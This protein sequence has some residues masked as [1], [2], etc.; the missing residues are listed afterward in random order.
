MALVQPLESYNLY[1]LGNFISD[2]KIAIDTG[3]RTYMAYLLSVAIAGGA[4]GEATTAKLTPLLV[5]SE[6]ETVQ[7]A[8]IAGPSLAQAAGLG[9]VTAEQSQAELNRG[10]GFLGGG[11]GRGDW[12]GGERGFRLFA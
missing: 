7:P 10:S 9:T 1:G 4:I 8:T 12:W 2:L 11:W 6:V 5:P 3:N